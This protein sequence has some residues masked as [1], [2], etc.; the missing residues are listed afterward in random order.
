MK[1][2]DNKH[3]QDQKADYKHRL[4]NITDPVKRAEECCRITDEIY[5]AKQQRLKKRFGLFYFL[6]KF[7][8]RVF[9]KEFRT[10]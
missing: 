2:K 9:N 4:H 8:K 1:M 3:L 7:W 6:Y 5:A 10:I